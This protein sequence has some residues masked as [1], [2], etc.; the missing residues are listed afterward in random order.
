MTPT[1][2]IQGGTFSH[3]LGSNNLTHEVLVLRTSWQNIPPPWDSLLSVSQEVCILE[4]RPHLLDLHNGIMFTV[5]T[6][7]GIVGSVTC[8]HIK[9]WHIQTAL[10]I[11]TPFQGYRNCLLRLH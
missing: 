6:F 4:K 9:K 1:M 11:G 5:W 7:N 3:S 2:S 8:G 10:T